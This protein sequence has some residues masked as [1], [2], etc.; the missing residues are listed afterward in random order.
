MPL[1]SAVRQ[2][3]RRWRSS[4]GVVVVWRP[5]VWG[6]MAMTG[7][8]ALGLLAGGDAA[9]ISPSY[10]VLRVLS[11]WGMRGYGPILAALCIATI[12][13][14]DRYTRGLG[15]RRLQLALSLCAG[16]YALWTVGTTAAW[17]VHWQI[18]AWPGP[19]RLA[20][21]SALCIVCARAIPRAEVRPAKRR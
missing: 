16:W 1:W 7:W 9:F 20:L 13:G 10:D 4:D 5:L 17:A 12:W 3:S 21:T 19:A 14:F 18:L 11:P 8:E 15:G 6:I 2:F